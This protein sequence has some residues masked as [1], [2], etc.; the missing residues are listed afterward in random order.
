MVL[1]WRGRGGR[2]SGGV[3]G[4]S[5][6]TLL[7]LRFGRPPLGLF[8]RPHTALFGSF[9]LK[10]GVGFEEG[11]SLQADRWKAGK[12]T[13]GRVGGGWAGMPHAEGIP[14]DVCLDRLLEGKGRMWSLTTPRDQ[15]V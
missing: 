2:A 11:T 12:R 5:P 10:A 14:P 7:L 6:A 4:S 8:I 3:H 15:I 1:R 9:G 13:E